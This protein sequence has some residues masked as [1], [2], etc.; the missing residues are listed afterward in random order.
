V[1]S[2]CGY[3][4]EARRPGLGDV[5]RWPRRKGE[6]VHRLLPR[7]EHVPRWSRLR[8]ACPTAQCGNEH[9]PRWPRS[10]VSMPTGPV[11]DWTYPAVALPDGEHLHRA[12]ERMDIMPLCPLLQPRR[13]HAQRRGEAAPHRTADSGHRTAGRGSGHR[14]AGRG[15]RV[16]SRTWSH[17]LRNMT[18]TAV[19]APAAGVT[20][21]GSNENRCQALTGRSATLP[22]SRRGASG[23]YS[24]YRPFELQA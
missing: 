13:E 8:G 15:P 3:P 17:R 2:G 12:R 22:F 24:A 21:L 11:R 9:V 18:A 4:D 10:R 16:R 23:D 20:F 14:T 1:D 5:P 6:H 7:N 19:H